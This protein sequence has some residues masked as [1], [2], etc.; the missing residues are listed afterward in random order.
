MNAEQVRDVGR[1]LGA[2][3]DSPTQSGARTNQPQPQDDLGKEWDQ[4]LLSIM[5]LDFDDGTVL[6]ISNNGYII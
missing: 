6:V 4:R 5:K 2:F 1:V 3:D